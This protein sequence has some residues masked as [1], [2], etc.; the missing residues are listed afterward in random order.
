M[1]KV[2]LLWLVSLAW[3]IWPIGPDIGVPQILRNGRGYAPHPVACPDYPLLRKADKVCEKERIYKEKRHELTNPKLI[4]FLRDVAKLPDFDAEHFITSTQ[5]IHNITI[6]VA[7]SGGSYRSMLTGAGQVLALDDRYA[8]LKTKGLGGLLQSTMYF[9]G[10]SG[11]AWLVGTLALNDWISVIDI[12]NTDSGIWNLQVPLISP[13]GLNIVQSVIDLYMIRKELKAKKKAGYT[14]TITDTWGRLLSLETLNP[15]EF[16]NYGENLTWSD[17]QYMASFQNYTM[18]IPLIYASGRNPLTILVDQNST[19]F[20]YTPFEFGTWDPRLESFVDTKYIGT[21]LDNGE[22]PAGCVANYDNAGFVMGSASSFWNGGLLEIN[23]TK[24]PSFLKYIVRKILTPLAIDA[25]DVAEYRPNPFYLSNDTR[26]HSFGSSKSLHIVDGGESKRS[27]PFDLLHIKE[28]SADILFGFDNSYDAERWPDGSSMSNSF[29]R[30]FTPWGKKG[31]FPFV[32][33][34]ETMAKKGF[35][36]KPV[37]YG[38]D[39][40]KL[41]P[42]VTYL[43]EGQNETD[44]PLIVYV[45]NTEY[46]YASNVSTAKTL[47]S[48]K[49]KRAFIEN[50]FSISSLGNYS[51]DLNWPTCVGCAVIRRQQE[52]LGIAP[53]EKC[54]QCFDKYCWQGGIEESPRP[55]LAP[56]LSQIAASEGKANTSVF[57]NTSSHLHARFDNQKAFVRSDSASYNQGMSEQSIGRS[58]AAIEEQWVKLTVF[59]GGANKHDFSKIL[60]S[61]VIAVAAV[62]GL[63]V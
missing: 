60:R 11:G 61:L 26:L 7:I 43:G 41:S 13:G 16:Y 63:F 1:Q 24:V 57:S 17:V 6:G 49:E 45:P 37:F 22:H 25:I 35:N 33:T 27:V 28:R 8:D 29:L 48:D 51:V 50:G 3:A 53:S 39:A 54:Q 55:D 34:V 21:P 12:L 52:R 2:F 10:L 23:S 32:P 18:P 20:E 58:R 30:Q 44:V 14:T 15:T 56:V 42:L 5:Y 36:K 38:C 62:I 31:A 47:F 4:E 46:T 40:S 59:R 19:T 9:S